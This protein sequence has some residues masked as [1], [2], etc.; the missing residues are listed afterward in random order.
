[1]LPCGIR[2][3][4]DA[5]VCRQRRIGSEV[6]PLTLQVLV[7]KAIL[8]QTRRISTIGE[9]IHESEI[10]VGE[11]VKRWDWERGMAEATGE[12]LSNKGSGLSDSL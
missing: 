12:M 6:A 1:M 8:H 7:G 2:G 5:R 11:R 4:G 10:E 9:A 3:R